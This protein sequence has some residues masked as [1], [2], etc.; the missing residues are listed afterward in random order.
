MVYYHIGLA[1]VYEQVVKC[2]WLSWHVTCVEHGSPCAQA[3][4]NTSAELTAQMSLHSK[5]NC[6]EQGRVGSRVDTPA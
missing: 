2:E 1:S 6:I 4:E 3:A 5:V